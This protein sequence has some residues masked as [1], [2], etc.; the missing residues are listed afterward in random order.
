M[1][2]LPKFLHYGLF[3]FIMGILVGGLLA[4]VNSFT[5]PIIAQ[6][7]LD[8]AKE[9][10]EVLVPDADRIVDASNDYGRLPSGLRTVFHAYD[11]NNNLETVLYWTSTVGWEA[12]A[13]AVITAIDV[14]SKKI[15]GAYVTSAVG[16]TP[17]Y[18]MKIF[19]HDF[20]FASKDAA[21][22]A[23]LDIPALA[24]TEF[25]IISGATISS[26]AVILGVQIATKHFMGNYGG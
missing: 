20:K 26:K 17:G 24:N 15:V 19:D 2:K 5:A 8:K 10:F 21:I 16:Q 25:D 4:L 14:S 7:E 9:Y 11:A 13:I 6:K 23:E 12:G 22:Y 3:L 18:G 1:N